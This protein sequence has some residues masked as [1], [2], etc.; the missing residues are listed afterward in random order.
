MF[1]NHNQLNIR[2]P[3]KAG[4]W[5]SADA[6][7]L[8]NTLQKHLDQVPALKETSKPRM[9]VVPH[10]GLAF[11]GPTAAYAYKAAATHQ[12]RNIFLIGISHFMGFPGVSIG[13]YQHYETPLGNIKVN[14]DIVNYLLKIDPQFTFVP[15]AHQNENSLEMQLPFIKYIFPDNIQIIPCLL[16]SA[17][18]AESL[19]DYLYKV[20]TPDDL[21]IISSDFS[22]YPTYEDAIKVDQET[23]KAALSGDPD[24]F[25]T[26]LQDLGQNPPPNCPCFACGENAILSGLYLAQKL[27]LHQAE[28]LHYSNS[29]D[30]PF[31]DKSQ[32]VGYGALVYYSDAEEKFYDT[33]Y[34]NKSD[35]QTLLNIVKE[36]LQKH[37][38][39]QK[40][41]FKNFQISPALKTTYGVFVTL[42]KQG[43]LRGCIGNFEPTQPLYE[44]VSQMALS[45]AFEDPRFNP[46]T[47]EEVTKLDIEISILSARKKISDPL[48]IIPGKHGV[49]IQLNAQGGT[50]LPQVAPE[51]NWDRSQMMNSLCEH[52]SGLPQTC[53][54]DGTADIYTYTA[55]VFGT[56]NF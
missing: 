13:N 14:Q 34:L 43:Q 28:L 50:Y 48:E 7:E 8:A 41:D 52:K 16:S 37:F 9:I 3:A 24:I 42:K 11:G 32:V 19:A 25:K 10:P 53:W 38:L 49:F 40:I 31:G 12:Y 20:I 1:F 44:L 17:Q 21:I 6:Q 22:H 45:S 18:E 47:Q 29:G 36:T 26:K 30:F 51:Q 54:Q 39:D 56:R 4:S 23:I 46:L 35:K 55:L 33:P 2:K 15:T 5:Y 27:N